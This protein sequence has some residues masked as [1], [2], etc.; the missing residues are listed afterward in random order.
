MD[1][2]P[3]RVMLDQKLR[4]CVDEGMSSLAIGSTPSSQKTAAVLIESC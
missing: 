2:E 4:R 1:T 3:G